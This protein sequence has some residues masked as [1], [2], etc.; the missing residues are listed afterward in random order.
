MQ[1]VSAGTSV[2]VRVLIGVSASL[3]IGVIVQVNCSQADWVSELCV[4]WRM[5]KCRV[6]VLAQPSA[7]VYW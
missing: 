5:V 7:L 6:S 1:C 3:Y 4:P 2:R